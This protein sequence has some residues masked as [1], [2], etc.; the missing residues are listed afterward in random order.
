MNENV[1]AAIGSIYEEFPVEA[2]Y[3]FGSVARR[4]HTPESDVDILVVFRDAPADPFEA[5]YQVRK[6]LHQRLDMALDVVVTSKE[7]FAR[8]HSQPWTIEHVASTEGVAV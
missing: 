1:R 2:I 7:A 4:E 5:A 8:R 6:S 3:L